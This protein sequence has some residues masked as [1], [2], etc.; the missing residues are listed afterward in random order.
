[1]KAALYPH[2]VKAL[3]V[4]Y[5]DLSQERS[6]NGTSNAGEANL[7]ELAGAVGVERSGSSGGAS[8]RGSRGGSPAADAELIK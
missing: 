5:R 6:S 2:D 4:E 3:F 7:R 1:V 8:G